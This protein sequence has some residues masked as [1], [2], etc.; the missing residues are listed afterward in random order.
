MDHLRRI[1]LRN[2]TDDPVRKLEPEDLRRLAPF[3]GLDLD[4]DT[5]TA[6]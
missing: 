3:L 1:P 6:S 4:L 2:L 5:T